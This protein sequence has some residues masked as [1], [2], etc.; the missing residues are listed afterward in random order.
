MSLIVAVGVF[1]AAA[2]GIVSAGPATERV[3]SRLAS[4]AG[5][6]RS[7]F[8][9]IFLGAS[10]SMPGIVVTAVAAMRGNLGLAV[11]NALGGILAQAAFIGVADLVSSTPF[12]SRASTRRVLGQTALVFVLVG[13]LIMA[14]ARPAVALGPVHPVTPLLVVTYVAGMR[15]VRSLREDPGSE[16]SH[17]EDGGRRAGGRQD[18]GARRLWWRYGL[19]IAVL[20][21]AG[22]AVSFA[23]DP[24]SGALGLSGS[25]AGAVLTAPATS[26]PELVTAISA[27]RNDR[28]RIAM[29]DLIG[30]NTFDVLM[31]AV[32]DVFA[33][34]PLFP[35]LGDASILLAGGVVLLHAVV[36]VGLLRRPAGVLGERV[37]PESF[38][39]VV[40]YVLVSVAIVLV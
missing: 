26:L 16:D 39:M 10:T 19:L 5:G 4:R 25:A 21:V 33:R 8:A 31:V 28:P 18:D 20:F 11:T 36:L 14:F 12:E 2:A 30:S 27:A 1:L 38:A 13:L 7:V 23:V 3:T 24:I 37:D 22:L 40:L 35:A 29:G 32:A 6:D 9:A 17:P 15:V 34:E